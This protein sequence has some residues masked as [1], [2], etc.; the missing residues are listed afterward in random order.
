MRLTNFRILFR[1]LSKDRYVYV[2]KQYIEFNELRKKFRIF[3]HR[4]L[5][6]IQVT[7]FIRNINVH[8]SIHSV[9]SGYLSKSVRLKYKT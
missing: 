7:I 9:L 5:V 4:L 6:K 1:P 3:Y 8:W 2:N